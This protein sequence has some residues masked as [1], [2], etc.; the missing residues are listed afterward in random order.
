MPKFRKKPVVI[1][2]RQLTGNTAELYSVYQWI[3]ANTLRSFEPIAVIEHH[4]GTVAAS[5][6]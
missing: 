5:Q 1:E 6:S 4:W 3:E 2:A